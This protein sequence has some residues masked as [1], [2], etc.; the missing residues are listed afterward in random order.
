M[1][2][3]GEVTTCSESCGGTV[4]M[5]R[6]VAVTEKAGGKTCVG[7]NQKDEPCGEDCPGI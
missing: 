1:D 3:T 6:K 4:K 2:D 7:D 5:T